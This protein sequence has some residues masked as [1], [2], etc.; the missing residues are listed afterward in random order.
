ME[1][2]AHASGAALGAPAAVAPL[3]IMLRDS[4]ECLVYKVMA[5]AAVP[6]VQGDGSSSSAWCTR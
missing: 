4:G 6:G 3:L 5:A 1:C 2:F